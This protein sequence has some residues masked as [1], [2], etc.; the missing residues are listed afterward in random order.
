MGLV[1]HDYLAHYH[2]SC[3]QWQGLIF[4]A[5]D[6]GICIDILQ[7]N[8]PSL[9]QY[10]SKVNTIFVSKFVALGIIQILPSAHLLRHA[11]EEQG[12]FLNTLTHQR[13]KRIYDTMDSMMMSGMDMDSSS[14]PL[15]RVFNQKL[16]RGY[17]YIVAGVV[18]VILLLR[19]VEYYQTWSRSVPFFNRAMDSNMRIEDPEI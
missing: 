9:S 17:W 16:A 4:S 2:A 10:P 15:F 1:I 13:S 11:E 7:R 19:T 18:G 3:S 5:F 6:I 14:D 12:S 8:A